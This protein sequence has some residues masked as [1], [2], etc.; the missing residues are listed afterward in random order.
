M[1]I[2]QEARQLAVPK[3]EQNKKTEPRDRWLA[4]LDCTKIKPPFLHRAGISVGNWRPAV[5]A[6]LMS[7]AQEARQLVVPRDR[8]LAQLDTAH[9]LAT[10]GAMR[11]RHFVMSELMHVLGKKGAPKDPTIVRAALLES[12]LE[13]VCSS[14]LPL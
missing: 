5:I 10:V 9:L 14:T 4:Q 2:A 12:A 8:W 3:K 11:K 7:I 6:F 1:S 13:E